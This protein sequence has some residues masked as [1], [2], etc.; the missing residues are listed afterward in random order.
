MKKLLLVIPLL[1]FVISGG[2]F[3]S[4][5][6]MGQRIPSIML[7]A[8][9]VFFGDVLAMTVG[10]YKGQKRFYVFH[11]NSII[12]YNEER[13]VLSHVDTSGNFFPADPVVDSEGNVYLMNLATDEIAHLSPAGQWGG[14]FKAQERPVSLAL[15]SNGNIVIASPSD[16]K[17]IH[18]YDTSGRKLRSFGDVK[19]LDVMNDAQNTFLNR[20]KVVV[21]S[22]DNIYFVFKYAPTVLKF[23]EE[24]EAYLGICN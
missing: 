23:S 13:S 9:E 3:A 21:D 7:Q 6:S 15:L 16:G 24:G 18:I 10:A 1:P 11:S 4:T 20:G 8:S 2:Y 17:L 22:S 14:S 19:P 12:V 5:G